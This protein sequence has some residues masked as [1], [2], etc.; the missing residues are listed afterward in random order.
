MFEPQGYNISETYVCS[1]EKAYKLRHD[2]C[3]NEDYIVVSQTMW[4]FLDKYFKA[5]MQ[6]RYIEIMR[7]FYLWLNSH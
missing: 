3:I 7:S 6:S 5:G 4:K 1:E 2:A